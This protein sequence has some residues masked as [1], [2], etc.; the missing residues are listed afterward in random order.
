MTF[1]IRELLILNPSEHDAFEVY[2]TETA[3]GRSAYRIERWKT[4]DLMAGQQARLPYRVLREH[5]GDL[6]GDTTHEHNL[7]PLLDDLSE[8]EKEPLDQLLSIP[9]TVKYKNASGDQFESSFV[10]THH[11]KIWYF[12]KIEIAPIASPI[13]EGPH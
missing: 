12:P 1:V 8:S 4:I 10:L 13:Y 7:K 5:D 6:Y 2:L 9:L 3:L 11:S